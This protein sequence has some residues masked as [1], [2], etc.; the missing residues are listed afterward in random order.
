M[1][2]IQRSNNIGSNV[3]SET[4]KNG[5]H[6]TVVGSRFI[7]HKRLS[8]TMDEAIREI[9]KGTVEGTVLLTDE[10]TAGRGRFER[11]WFSGPGD[12]MF[13]VVFYLSLIHISEP[14]RPY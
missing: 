12:L 11:Q 4:L 2:S 8:S 7:Y 5:L 1:K 3:I 6:T 14:T 10:Q 9:N 13:S